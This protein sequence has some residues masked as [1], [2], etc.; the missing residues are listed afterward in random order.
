MGIQTMA[1]PGGGGGQRSQIQSLA[2]QGSLYS[3]TLNEVQSQL[4]EPLQSMNLEELLKGLDANQE[5]ESTGDQYGSSSALQGQG[6]ITMP[7]ALRE[8]RVDEVWR[9]IQQG[10]SKG[11]EERRSG[12]ERQLTF[13][14]MTLEDFLAKAGVV[15]EGSGKN[16][17][18]LV[19]NA[20][21]DTVAGQSQ[22]Y[23]RGPH[24]LHQYHQIPGMDQQN[25]M[26]SYLP[27]RS[28]SQPVGVGS[29]QMM[30]AMYPEG[31]M[32]LSSP[33]VGAM[34][35]PQT[36]GRKRGASSGMADKFVERRHKRMI[37]NRESA[38][39]SRARKQVGK[40]ILLCDILSYPLF[41]FIVV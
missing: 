17:N 21:A 14:E 15:P 3:L 39:R 27:G 9:D 8:K 23:G 10:H 20:G 30:D 36:P 5:V 13:G 18:N 33:T 4:G 19:E 37:K 2:R 16:G 41:L 6:S 7:R 38:A 32:G 31:Q 34:S 22:Q 1:S 26:G 11:S 24:W 29:G 12:L 25:V 40:C 28:V 35:D